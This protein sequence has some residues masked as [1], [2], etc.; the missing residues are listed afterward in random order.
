MKNI[1]RWLF[2]IVLSAFFVLITFWQGLLSSEAN[3]SAKIITFFAFTFILTGIFYIFSKVYNF[4]KRF[5]KKQ[6]NNFTNDSSNAD[7]NGNN[8]SDDYIEKNEKIS[9]G[10]FISF[11]IFI[12]VLIP[13]SIFFYFG[14]ALAFIPMA[15]VNPLL[16]SINFSLPFLIFNYIF[17][18]L[19]KNKRNVKRGLKY[20]FLL[21]IIFFIVI[22]GINGYMFIFDKG[23]YIQ[24]EDIKTLNEAS[25][26]DENV[27]Y[28]VKD[29][30]LADHCFSTRASL[31]N[32]ISLCYKIKNS[33]E[34]SHCLSAFSLKQED[35]SYCDK[36]NVNSDKIICIQNV[37]A[38]TQNPEYCKSL[39]GTNYIDACYL[40]AIAKKTDKAFI[41]K[42]CDLMK[43]GMVHQQNCIKLLK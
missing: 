16:T 27:C 21:S 35:M 23:T 14:A 25:P 42:Y 3:I 37:A 26:T 15:I 4:V 10:L 43:K 40:G 32:D 34:L 30:W 12:I 17:Y 36:I 20:G 18:L 38:N 8:I 9:K 33:Q 13:E 31:T 1:F 24:T 29:V 39:L 11:I 19:N 5:L 6:S 2:K 22:F 7:I 41:A 28:K